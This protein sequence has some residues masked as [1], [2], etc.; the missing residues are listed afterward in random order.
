MP[1]HTTGPRRRVTTAAV[2]AAT[3]ATL[4]LTGCADLR[5]GAPATTDPCARTVPETRDL[6]GPDLTSGAPTPED[7]AFQLA[8]EDAAAEIT[9]LAGDRLGGLWL[10]WA[11]ERRLVV[12]L[13]P[14]P[15]IPGL[16][17]AVA[18]ADVVVDV[19]E[20]ATHGRGALV[21]AANGIG[22]RTHE[23]PGVGGSWV[24]EQHGLLVYSV[25]SGD[26]DGAATCTALAEILDEAGVPY[27]FEVFEG[28]TES[29]VRTTVGFGEAWTDDL[30][31]QV[32]A[33]SCNGEPEITV[34]EE[35]AD[36]VRVEI[37]ATVPAPGWGGNACLDTVVVPL[38]EPLGERALVDLTTGRVVPA[39]ERRYG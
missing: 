19:R 32:N 14:G 39:P 12:A 10:E 36:E 7:Q 6:P 25:A 9:A 3:A 13:T 27:A 26:D 35:T 15:E 28:P 34:L 17:D 30:G 31:L 11:P 8:A 24:D 16:D 18:A 1:R 37:T 5:A 21:A 4:L 23:V 22:Q 33:G 29:T 2:V 20:T 38:A